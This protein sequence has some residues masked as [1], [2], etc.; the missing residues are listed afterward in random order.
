MQPELIA[1]IAQ[2]PNRLYVKESTFDPTRCATSS[3]SARGLDRVCPNVI[4]RWSAELF[5]L[6]TDKRGMDAALALY[7]KITAAAV[8][9][10]RPAL[11]LGRQGCVRD[12]GHADGAC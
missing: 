1:R 4:P 3:G 2:I 11:R 10:R 6:V 12:D 8:V 7:M 9:G 5:N